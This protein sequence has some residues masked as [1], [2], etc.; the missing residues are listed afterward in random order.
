[1]AI[2]QKSKEVNRKNINKWGIPRLLK[3]GPHTEMINTQQHR[4]NCSKRIY[5]RLCKTKMSCYILWSSYLK[6]AHRNA[7]RMQKYWTWEILSKKIYKKFRQ[8][9][10]LILIWQVHS[11]TKRSSQKKKE[12]KR[13]CMRKKYQMQ[14]SSKTSEVCMKE[15]KQSELFAG[16]KNAD[17]GMLPK[18]KRMW[19][20]HM[21]EYMQ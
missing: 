8:K 7:K 4:N 6:Y 19:C 15:H 3:H 20:D 9:Q 18:T 11:N 1:M 10:V 5:E 17:T 13:D 2:E 16:N 21:K 12:Y 14:H